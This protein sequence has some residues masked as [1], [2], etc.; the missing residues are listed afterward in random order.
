MK[1]VVGFGL[2]EM[3]EYSGRGVDV[4]FDDQFTLIEAP[5][6]WMMHVAKL[7]S[8]SV[9]TARKYSG[10]LA[11]FLQ[12]LDD[13]GYGSANW[14]CVDEEIFDQY[15][16]FIS[17]TRPGSD[18]GPLQ[19]TTEDSAYRIV[20]FYDWAS[21]A[22]YSHYLD[23]DTEEIEIRLKDQALL[24]HISG[25]V[26]RRKLDFNL[27]SGRPA[28]FHTEVE[29]FVTQQDYVVALQLLSDPVFRII[30][31]VIRTTGM[32]PKEL[33][34]IPYLGAKE[35][36]GFVPYDDDLVP[37]DLDDQV[38]DFFCRS[39][40]KNRRI[41]FPGILWRMICEKY[42]PMRR[43]RAE[44]FRKRTGVSPRNSVLFLTADGYAVDY[45]ILRYHFNQVVVR[46]DLNRSVGCGL[47]YARRKF[48]PRMLR[49][50]CATYFIFE[51]LRKG[52]LIGKSFVYD[53]AVD[54]DLRDLMG[55]NDVKTS[56]EYYVHLAN[57]FFKNDLL[58]DLHAS[59]VDAGL[60]QVLTHLGYSQ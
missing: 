30:A 36:S 22:G 25:G 6:R 60:S 49:H 15:L 14:Y 4:Y 23:I 20:G 47:V 19:S 5:T 53:A 32:R 50:S 33:L 38:I 51:S 1:R 45:E 27:P 2:A 43:E 35:N 24:A 46:S 41:K 37:H 18:F 28:Y 7:R 58:A 29:K 39:K 48:T 11:R 34:Q 56:Y 17:T 55:H 52:N 12:W 3:P 40:G 16:A 54:E 57:R 26:Q 10:I 13:S 9:E 31:A 42:V 59:R 21:R 8:R 44:L